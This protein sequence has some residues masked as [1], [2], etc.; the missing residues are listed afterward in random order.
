VVDLPGH[1]GSAKE[2]GDYSLG[3]LASTLRD[4]LDHLGYAGCILVGHSL[5]GGV[6]MQFAYQFPERCDGLVLVASGGL[7][8]EASPF[9]R[10]ASLP[11]AE[12]VLPLIAHPRTLGAV[13]AAGR[14]LGALHR[15]GPMV[16]DE[17][18]STLRELGDPATRAAFLATLRGVV[19][20]TGQRVSAVGK[21]PA[22]SHLPTLLVWGDHDPII[23]IAHGRAT[24]EL[25]PQ[26]RLVV[27]PGAGHE[28]HR[29]DPERFA[30]LVL[31]HPARL[32]Q[33]A[34]SS[35]RTS[36]AARSPVRR[37]PSINPDQAPAVH[38]PASTKPPRTR[39]RNSGSTGSPPG[40]APALG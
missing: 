2:R 8:R 25:L 23:P 18:L 20:I 31:D 38:S 16:A 27:F 33:L 9:L 13:A 7:G 39:S 32:G 37:A 21:L 30:Q 15:T 17:S 29:H 10:A 34:A 5:G 35:P 19:D 40:H 36:A 24:V 6:A 11:G 28:P 3:A 4:L 14:W 12:F 22:A 26:G 1:G